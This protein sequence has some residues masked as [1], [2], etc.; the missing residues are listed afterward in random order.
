MQLDRAVKPILP[1]STSSLSFFI[2]SFTQG[3]QVWIAEVGNPIGGLIPGVPL[4]T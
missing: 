3:S 4:G 1:A 2:C